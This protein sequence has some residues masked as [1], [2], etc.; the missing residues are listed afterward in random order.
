MSNGPPVETPGPDTPDRLGKQRVESEADADAGRSHAF[1]AESNVGV[2]DHRAETQRR[3][4]KLGTPSRREI[5]PARL[6]QLRA[7]GYGD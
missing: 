2:R 1:V 5:D 3:A 7:L 6:E 4:A